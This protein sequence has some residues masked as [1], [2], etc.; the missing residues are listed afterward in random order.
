MKKRDKKRKKRRS[1]I[2]SIQRLVTIVS[3]IIFG[4]STIMTLIFQNVAFEI[5]L[6][7]AARNAVI[8]ADQIIQEVDGFE[9]YAKEVMRIYSSVPEKTR[10]A[11][12]EEYFAYFSDLAFSDCCI[13][14]TAKLEW[15]SERFTFEN[16]YF[17]MFDKETETVVYLLDADKKVLL[18]DTPQ[19]NIIG[20]IRGL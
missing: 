11:E 12:D 1:L 14:A 17:A 2:K 20:F 18:K 13:E 6:E 15:L 16:V 8:G 5:L 3:L 9:E 7:R 19:E 4:A 10:L